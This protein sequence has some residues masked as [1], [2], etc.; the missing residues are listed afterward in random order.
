MKG[1]NG[2]FWHWQ[3]SGLIL[4][5]IVACFSS[6]DVHSVDFAAQPSHAGFGL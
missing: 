2:G 3:V 4:S 1:L 6:P 5:S